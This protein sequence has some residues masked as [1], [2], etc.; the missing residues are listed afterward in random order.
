[1]KKR[2]KSKVAMVDLLTTPSPRSSP[3]YDSPNSAI[4]IRTASI[5]KNTKRTT[6]GLSKSQTLKTVSNVSELKDLASTRLDELKNLI[7]SSHSEIL[8]NLEASQSRLR[9]RLKMQTQSCQQ[10]MDEADKEYK[11]VSERIAENQ[12][13]MK[14][15]YSEFIADAQ[16][17]S[18]R[19]SKTSIADLSQSFDKAIDSLR[20]RFGISST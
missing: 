19:A 5:S 8:N 15:S 10:I 3:P 4:F 9:K 2:G 6:V 13:L 17:N 1:M 16:I 12:E 18:S 14:A 20:K 7:D 11:K